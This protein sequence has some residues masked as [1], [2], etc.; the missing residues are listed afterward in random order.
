MYRG[1]H[2]YACTHLH[3]VPHPSERIPNTAP[4]LAVLFEFHILDMFAFMK[5]NLIEEILLHKKNL[6]LFSVPIFPFVSSLSFSFSVLSSHIRIWT[7]KKISL[8]IH[9]FQ[10]FSLFLPRREKTRKSDNSANKCCHPICGPISSKQNTHLIFTFYF[11]NRKEITKKKQKYTSNF[12]IRKLPPSHEQS[13]RIHKRLS[14][15][16]RGWS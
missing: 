1:E 3:P 12:T 14:R 10:F 5:N 4:H 8:W 6:V 7:T 15:W 2:T 11:Q 16:K 9:F 13:T